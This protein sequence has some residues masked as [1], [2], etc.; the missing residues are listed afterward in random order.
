[1]PS[2][3]S[4]RRIWTAAAVFVSIVC[5]ACGA[6]V[7]DAQRGTLVPTGGEAVAGSGS[8]AAA[9][10]AI[11][12]GRVEASVLAAGP[13]TPNA[14]GSGI[15]LQRPRSE[16]ANGGATDVGVT[17]SEIRVGN[18]S[19]LSGP[20]PGL[21]QG[22]AVGALAF[23]AYQNSLGGIHGRMLKVDV[24]DDQFDTGENRA[25]T[26]EVA[27]QDFA[28]AGSFSL[29]E[30][31]GAAIVSSTGIPDVGVSLSDERRK[32]P[33]SF[34]PIGAPGRGYRTGQFLWYARHFPDAV[35]AVGTLFGDVASGKTSQDDMHRAAQSAGWRFIYERGFTAAE[36]DFTA[37]VV[38]MRESGVKL[39]YVVVADDKSMARIAKSM[40]Q[41]NWHP[42]VFA[43]GQT[44]YDRDLLTLAGSAVE[45]M[46]IDQQVAMYAGEDAAQVPEVKLLDEWL[47]KV[48]PGLVPD[49]YAAW[50]WTSMRLLAQTIDAVGPNLTRSAVVDRLRA[51]DAFDSNGLASPAWPGL[52]RPALCYVI[53]QVKDRSYQRVDPDRGFLCDG[54]WV[55]NS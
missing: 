52:R 2:E 10:G 4:R 6:R 17:G 16:G 13:A 53:L 25:E 48:K 12:P 35:K 15:D 5:A 43:V 46:Y 38:R 28:I 27:A 49:V 54:S 1:M 23:A 32:L 7:S 47:Q 37:D 50:A 22:A 42:Q 20:A 33:T 9:A 34:S 44:G 11:G 19:T 3:E 55:A 40:A 31:G 14:T 30:S 24:R 18:V 8:A 36:T 39:V 45:G 21:F 41:Q 29:L 26:S 51:T